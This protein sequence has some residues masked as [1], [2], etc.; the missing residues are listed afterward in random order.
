[1]LGVGATSTLAAWTSSQYAAGDVGTSTFALESRAGTS[2]S[3]TANGESNPVKL[4]LDATGLSP[5]TQKI[6][7]LDVRTTAQSTVPGTLALSI[8]GTSTS[9]AQPLISYLEYR[10]AVIPA[11]SSCVTGSFTGSYLPFT[12]TPG[13]SSQTVTAQGESTVRYCLQ[14]RMKSDNVP[15]T[16]QGATGKVALTVTGTSQ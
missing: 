12:Q 11:T 13:T 5:G 8:S 6:A 15:S 7:N 14:V 10:T 16:I 3:F 2:G 9:G 4:N 1:M